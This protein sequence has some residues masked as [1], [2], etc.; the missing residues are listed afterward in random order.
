MYHHF[1]DFFNL[2]ASLH[3]NGS[4]FSKNERDVNILIWENRPYRS[5][6]GDTFQAFS[7]NPIQNLNTY[8]GKRVCFKEVMFPLLPRMLWG[9]F[10]NTPLSPND[11][12]NSALFK[13]FSEFITDRLQIET[14]KIK[15]R[16]KVTILAR[17]TKHR[18]ILNLPLLHDA[19]IEDGNFEVTLAPF[20][21]DFPSFRQVRA[22]D[23]IEL[24]S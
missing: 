1:C 10:Y 23:Y 7:E 20:T 18:Q 21:H 22:K 16:I 6:F 11:C 15:Q 8:A 24:M 3:V 17:K 14:P 4:S 5:A 9:L 12:Q 2:Y 19:L 13:S